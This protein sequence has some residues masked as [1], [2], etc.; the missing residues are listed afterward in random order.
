MKIEIDTNKDS[1][2]MWKKIQKL[3]ESDYCQPAQK[4]IAKPGRKEDGA[5]LRKV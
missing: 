3:I 1:Y 2:D 4:L 5:P